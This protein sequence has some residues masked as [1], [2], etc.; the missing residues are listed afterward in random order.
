M[1]RNPR[2]QMIAVL[3]A[4]ALLG[5]VAA[6]GKV[7]YF[8]TA[9]GA[10]FAATV[11]PAVSTSSLQAACCTKYPNTPEARDFPLTGIEN[12]RPKNQGGGT[13][14]CRPGDAPGRSTRVHQTAEGMGG[15]RAR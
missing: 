14:A 15:R 3:A 6:S 13:V 9:D 2:V 12:A 7:N 1:F 11:K 10:Q 4:G 8:S 5:Y